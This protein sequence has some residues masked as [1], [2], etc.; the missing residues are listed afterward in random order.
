MEYITFLIKEH[1]TVLHVFSALKK[2]HWH[3]HYADGSIA[4]RTTSDGG[5]MCLGGWKWFSMFPQKSKSSPRLHF[6]PLLRSGTE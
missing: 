6:I 1:N 2:T 4:G 5:C 3:K